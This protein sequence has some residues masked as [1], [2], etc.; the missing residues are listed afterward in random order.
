MDTN[1]P[2]PPQL[3]DNLAPDLPSSM[4]IGP[5]LPGF[6]FP[7]TYARAEALASHPTTSTLLL[8]NK[9]DATTNPYEN[10]TDELERLPEDS[11]DFSLVLANRS[12]KLNHNV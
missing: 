7:A 9:D 8:I 6:I 12:H 3:Q 2:A 5:S 11:F 4:A 1:I 10:I